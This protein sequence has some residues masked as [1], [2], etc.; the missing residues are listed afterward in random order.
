VESLNARIPVICANASTIVGAEIFNSNLWSADSKGIVQSC[1]TEFSVLHHCVGQI[2][3]TCKMSEKLC[4]PQ[5]ATLQKQWNIAK[6][7]LGRIVIFSEQPDLHMRIEAFFSGLKSLLDLMVQLLS[8][9]RIVAAAI[10]GFH[11]DQSGYGGSVLKALQNNSPADRKTLA[12]KIEALLREQKD[13]WIDSAI[14]ARD[15]LVHPTRGMSQ[16]MFQL[17]CVEMD[18][19]LLFTKIH[20]PKIDSTPIDQYAHRTLEHARTFGSAFTA[21]LKE[22]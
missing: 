18:G 11:R 21:L 20:P 13:Q 15:L 6:F 16:L 2:D 14:R 8:S 17:D 4:Q 5:I 22:K 19:K 12:A 1:L 3:A 7:D 9:E 10:H